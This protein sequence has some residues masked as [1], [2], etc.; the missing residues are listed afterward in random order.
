MH[1]ATQTSNNSVVVNFIQ[2]EKKFYAY[3]IFELTYKYTAACTF[4][5]QSLCVHNLHNENY[6]LYEVGVTIYNRKRWEAK[7]ISNSFLSLVV[8]KY[9][10]ITI[11]LEM[12]IGKTSFQYEM[13]EGK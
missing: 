3:S 2:G 10:Y 1:P 13:V 5:K 7:M 11:N 8:D 6:K 12:D 4:Q 9:T